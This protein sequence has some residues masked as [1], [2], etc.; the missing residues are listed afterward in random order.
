[1]VGGLMVAAPT[2]AG[3]AGYPPPPVNSGS[4][5]CSVGGSITGTATGFNAGTQVSYPGG[6]GTSNASGNLTFS[7][8]CSDPHYSIN[9]GAMQTAV[10][11]ANPIDF[12]GTGPTGPHTFVYTLTIGT[13]VPAAVITPAKPVTPAA[14]TTPSSG[15]ALTGADIAMTVGGGLILIVGGG[16]IL[17]AVSRRQTAR[18]S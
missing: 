18:E 8:S 9:G 17:L 15:L 2:F 10:Y 5:S 3:A 11:G 16:A 13:A 14:V 7:I 4:G 12:T 6:S 1:M